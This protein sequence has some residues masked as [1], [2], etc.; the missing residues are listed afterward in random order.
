MLLLEQKEFIFFPG[1]IKPALIVF[2]LISMFKRGREG[3][4]RT[5]YMFF[6]SFFFSVK[7]HKNQFTKNQ[8]I[9]FPIKSTFQ[10]LEDLALYKFSS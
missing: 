3:L 5:D 10:S 8:Y 9:F 7:E 1:L 2:H 4:S 6:I